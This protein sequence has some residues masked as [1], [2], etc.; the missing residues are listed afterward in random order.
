MQLQLK[1]IQR[2]ELDILKKVHTIAVNNGLTYYAMGG[3]LLGAVRHGGFIPWDDDVDILVPRPEYDRFLEVLSRELPEYMTLRDGTT[4][5]DLPARFCKVFNTN[6][7]VK[8][9]ITKDKYAVTHVH[10]DVFPIDGYPD[11]EKAEK[12]FNKKQRLFS[13]MNNA[14]YSSPAIYSGIKKIVAKAFYC[15]FKPKFFA[16]KLNQLCMAYEYGKAEKSCV[17]MYTWG[18]IT[19]E[20]IAV[21]GQAKLLKFEDTEIFAPEY[22]EEY[23]TNCFGDYMTPPPENERDSTHQMIAEYNPGISADNVL[24]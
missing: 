16:E 20:K 22:T 17:G 4:D 24:L 18:D 15:L 21:Y 8:S 7:I 2:I 14:F 19:V 13:Q 6:T 10:I 9:C 23:L 11:D 12:T 3:T 5:F 1:E